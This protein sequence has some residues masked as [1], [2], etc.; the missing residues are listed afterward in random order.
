MNYEKII[1]KISKY[2]V[3][4]FDVFDTLIERDVS[5][6][7]NIFKRT[8]SRILGDG[9]A[10]EFRLKRIQAEKIARK[11]LSENEVTLDEIYEQLEGYETAV[12]KSLM[13]AEMKIELES[14]S[15]KKEMY[16]VFSWACENKSSVVLISDMYL[17]E[18][19]IDR[20]LRKCGYKG[21]KKIYVSNEYGVNKAS[22]K[23]YDLVQN[24]LSVQKNRVIHIGDSIRAD[25]IGAHR[26]GMHAI[27]VKRKNRL[28]RKLNI[29]DKMGRR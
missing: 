7:T 9:F 13:E 3:I 4:S 29:G 28:I 6:A 1:K 20:I 2:E 19:C 10:E 8:G 23:L 17:S 14:C 18:K 25:F 15:Q 16:K 5:D 22:G 21:Y 12:K 26:R 24:D 27:L 11:K